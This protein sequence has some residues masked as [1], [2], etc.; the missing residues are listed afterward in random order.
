MGRLALISSF[1][2]RW[3]SRDSGT[4]EGNGVRLVEGKAKVFFG[5]LTAIRLPRLLIFPACPH[6]RLSLSQRERI[7]VRDSFRTP[8][9]R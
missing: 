5:R 1:W 2:K 9:E 7:E 4:S 6:C 8:L 3:E